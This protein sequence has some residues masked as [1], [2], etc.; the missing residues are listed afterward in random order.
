[1]ASLTERYEETGAGNVFI[2]PVQLSS[3][4]ATIVTPMDI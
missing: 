2:D 1:M 4:Y 3:H